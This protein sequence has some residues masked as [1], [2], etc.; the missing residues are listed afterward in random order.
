MLSLLIFAGCNASI[1]SSSKQVSENPKVAEQQTS[2]E[3][4]PAPSPFFGMLVD[5]EQAAARAWKQFTKDGRYQIARA[6]DFKMPE[7]TKTVYY[8]SDIGLAMKY[9]YCD[10]DIN[11]DGVQNDFAFIVVDSTRNDAARFGIVIFSKRKDGK[12]YESPRWLF[13]DSDLSTTTLGR[14]SGGPM[15]IVQYREDGTRRFCYVKWNRQLKEY[16]CEDVQ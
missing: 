10:G 5:S 6:S 13:R 7:W 14:S 16:Y 4:S 12:D 1:E 11:R 9:P 8:S 3:P 2:E 15:H